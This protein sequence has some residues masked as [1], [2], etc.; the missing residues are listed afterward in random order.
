MDPTTVASIVAVAVI[1]VVAVVRSSMSKSKADDLV[2]YAQ[3][4]A[5]TS[6]LF[7]RAAEQAVVDVE[8]DLKQF[9]DMSPSELKQAAA[10]QAKAILEA[11][12]VFVSDD[13]LSALLSMVEEAYQR[14]KA[15]KAEFHTQIA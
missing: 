4:A 5:Q 14:L 12:G 9:G 10:E 13:M 7:M 6:L 11:W 8:N 15:S 3:V 2:K 1:A